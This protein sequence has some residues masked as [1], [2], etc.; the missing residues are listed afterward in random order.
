MLK[1]LTYSRS[2][3][4]KE[5]DSYKC[6]VD[7][8][9]REYEIRMTSW[10]DLLYCSQIQKCR[11]S[12]PIERHFWASEKVTVF[13]VFLRQIRLKQKNC[14][15]EQC[16]ANI[17]VALFTRKQ[18]A[19]ELAFGWSDRT[20]AYACLAF[21]S[22][23]AKLCSSS[24]TSLSVGLS[25]PLTIKHLLATSATAST[26]FPFPAASSFTLPSNI[27][28]NLPAATPS[29]NLFPNSPFSTDT[30][31]S[32]VNSSAITT[33]KPYTSPFSTVFPKNLLKSGS[34]YPSLSFVILRNVKQPTIIKSR[35][36]IGHLGHHP[37]VQQYILR[38]HPA[39][40]LRIGDGGVEAS[41]GL[42]R[43]RR[44]SQPIFPR[45]GAI[46]FVDVV[47]Q[48]AVGHILVDHHGERRFV[49]AGTEDADD[50]LIGWML[51]E[52]DQLA[53]ELIDMV[54][55]KEDPFLDSNDGMMMGV[56]GGGWE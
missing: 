40:E 31:N 12:S 1:L 5:A 42:C 14:V 53:Y 27:S 52:T 6:G 21:A 2:K 24:A 19:E 7:Q 17:G 13:G 44:D 46:E 33:P 15:G 37:L 47:V 54:L 38:F 43:H 4:K 55:T 36:K 3:I 41:Q 26:T 51:G 16:N 30:G 25:S 56:V 10:L 28:S 11:E 29:P 18:M 48:R 49:A 39:M 34:K 23:V 35:S 45:Q 50:V 20:T 32:P 8:S 9:S 22:Y